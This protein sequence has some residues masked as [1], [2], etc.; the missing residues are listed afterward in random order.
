MKKVVVLFMVMLFCVSFIG[1][2]KPPKTEKFEEVKS[3][4]TAFVIPLEGDMLAQGK[5]K[6]LEALQSYKVAIKRINIPRRW[7]KTGRAWYSGDWIDTVKI[8]KVNRTPVTREWIADTEKGSNRRDD[9][10][11]IESADSVTFSTGFTVTAKIMEIDT[12]LFLYNYTADSSLAKVM[13]SEVKA[14][15]QMISSEV[16]S[17]SKMDILRNKKMDITK[18]CRDDVIP[19]FKAKGITISTLGLFG[20]FQY[21]NPDIQ[22]SIDKT[23]I[24]QQEKVLAAAKLIAQVD[25]NKR[26]ELEAIAFKNKAIT[27]AT[28]EAEGIRLIAMAA[29]EAN[30]NPA[31]LALKNLEVESQRI[32]QWDGKYPKWYMGGNGESMGLIISPPTN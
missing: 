3:N 9:A 27:R 22:T 17:F 13:D 30:K 23:F 12:A 25:I 24:T 8:L 21:Q 31:F 4:E 29:A 11:W 14:R 28:G 15:I 16:A 19:F 6:S 2:C 18:A 32:A 20:G 1:G 10:I 26:I 5:M 7:H